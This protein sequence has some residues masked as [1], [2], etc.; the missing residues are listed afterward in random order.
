MSDKM[1]LLFVQSDEDL[2]SRIKLT[3]G[4]KT[5]LRTQPMSFVLRFIEL[6]GLDSL[7]NFLKGMSYEV[8]SSPIHTS[9]L[10]CLKAL[11]NSTVSKDV[12]FLQ[13]NYDLPTS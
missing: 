4:L 5:S 2:E 11:M 7:L 9:V 1:Q 3:D 10:G 13:T 8:S 6:G 12:L